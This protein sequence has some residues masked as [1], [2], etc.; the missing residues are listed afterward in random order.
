V[1][2]LINGEWYTDDELRDLEE[3]SK[4]GAFAREDSHFRAGWIATGP[5]T[6]PPDKECYPAD[7]A[8]YHLYVAWAC[9]WAHR[10]L[11]YRELLGLS[12]ISVSIVHPLMLRNGWTFASGDGTV[13]DPILDAQYLYQVYQSADRSYTGRVT[14]PVL[15]D[16]PSGTIVNN[17]SA[18]II[19]MLNGAFATPGADFYPEPLRGEIDALNE[20]IYDT[21]NNGVYKAGFATRQAAY[22]EAVS[23]L[24]ESLDW[25]ESRLTRRRYLTGDTVTEADWRLFPTL[26][27]FDSIYAI[28]FKCSRRRIVDYPNLWAYTRDLYQQKGVARTVNLPLAKMHYYRSHHA[29]NPH[30]I[31]ADTAAPE[32][33]APHQRADLA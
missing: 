15:W 10:T 22:D 6:A 12:Q 5:D 4:S 23:A 1:G 2:K 17:E 20:R 26:V 11:L 28:H 29:I 30:G 9:P 19:R 18:D 24:F 32:F 8:R 27:R 33:T 25:L 13:P 21:V 3:P 16:K 14:V 31:I 7:P